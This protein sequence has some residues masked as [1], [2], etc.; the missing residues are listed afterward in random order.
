[1]LQLIPYK[2]YE[3]QSLYDISTAVYGN[4]AF[5]CDLAQENNLAVTAN[6]QCGQLIKL[7]HLPVNSYV[8]KVYAN[9]NIIPATSQITN[10][11]ILLGVGNLGI[12]TTFIIN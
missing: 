11:N 10:E 2:V 5:A 9:N 7:V 1:M 12:G 6:L 4:A 8:T 3:G